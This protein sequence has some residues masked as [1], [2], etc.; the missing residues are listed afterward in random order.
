MANFKLRD[1]RMRTKLLVIFLLVS[2]PPLVVTAFVAEMKAEQGVASAV[3]IS[4]EVIE[5][6]ASEQMV[7]IRDSKA[8]RIEAYFQGIRDQVLTFSEDRM[9]VDAMRELPSKFHSYREQRGLTDE[10]ISSM[11]TELATYY[12]GEFTE[13]Y[14]ATNSGEDPGAIKYF[15][16]LDDDSI[17]L[18]HAFI[19]ANNFPL[20]SK[21]GLD[22]PEDRTDYSTLHETIHPPI[23]SYLQKFGY[24][25]IFLCD[26]DSGDIVYSVFKELDYTS[27][28]HKG[29]YSDSNFGEAFRQANELT[30]SDDFVFVDFEQYSPSYEA[31]ASFI[32]SPIFDGD[33]KLGVAIFQMPLDTI[34]AVMSLQS[35]LGVTGDSYMVGPDFLMRSD[36]HQDPENHGVVSSFK[37]PQAGTCRTEASIAANTGAKGIGLIENYAGESVIAA[38]MPVDILGVQW[39]MIAEIQESEAFASRATIQEFAQAKIAELVLWVASLVLA[40]TAL[41]IFVG[42]GVASMI[43]KPIVKSADALE[44]VGRGD[45]TPRLIIESK[46]EIGVMGGWLNTALDNLSAM[47][48]NVRAGAQELDLSSDE[49][50]N[51]SNQLSMSASQSAA[52]LQEIAA[53]L[54]EVSAMASQNAEKSTDANG[55]S[56]EAARSAAKGVSEMKDMTEA[57]Q[58][59]R[60]SSSEISKIIKV[61]DEIAFQTN[62]LALN[63]AVEAARAGEAGAGFAVVAEEVRSLAMRSAEAAQDTATKIEAATKRAEH[64]GGI[65]LRVTEALAEIVDSTEGV[66]T[67]LEDIASASRQQTIGIN[68]VSEGVRSVDEVTQLTA[69]SAEELATTSQDSARQ[70]ASLRKLVSAFRF[71]DNDSQ[72]AP[73]PQKP[74]A[75]SSPRPAAPL[76]TN[77]T[78][79]SEAAEMATLNSSYPDLSHDDH[80]ENF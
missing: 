23:R 50:S 9:V 48:R 79:E 59:I 17:A 62:L 35:G 11:R 28:L 37:N 42:I 78:M 6:Q 67:I 77:R 7:S 43:A 16:Q 75:I 22:T 66:H 31:P 14:R 73:M 69:R 20:G 25:D 71:E 70:S 55:L 29:P 57:M 33:Q 60:N 39:A 76:P 51:S 34:S 21:D 3:D 30:S 10:D 53:S 52:S 26:P 41:M 18:Q 68:Q 80:L 2:V 27:S 1:L 45:L 32:A 49:I 12:T 8:A 44:L 36:S 4:L 61:I 38:W 15:N 24:Y 13:E 74:A 46:D 54:E 56:A 65:A 47:M 58:A 64:G 63:A 40:V 19:R 5:K 72:P